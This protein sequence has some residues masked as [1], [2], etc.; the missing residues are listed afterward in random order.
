MTSPPVS[1]HVGRVD[2]HEAALGTRHGFQRVRLLHVGVEHELLR[3][4][5]TAGDALEGPKDAVRYPQ[6]R[7]QSGNEVEFRLAE[8]ADLLATFESATVRKRFHNGSFFL[9]NGTWIDN[10]VAIGIRSI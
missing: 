3:I 5:L 10:L 8:L 9:T 4:I 7:D 6:M 1:L 2:A